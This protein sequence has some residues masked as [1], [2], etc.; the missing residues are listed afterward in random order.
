MAGAAGW[1]G[2]SASCAGS[3]SACGVDCV[4][5]YTERAGR[6]VG[7]LWLAL[8][9]AE[10]V[11]SNLARQ[12]AV[13]AEGCA[14]GTGAD[15]TWDV[16]PTHGI[17][18]DLA[19]DVVG[20]LWMMSDKPVQRLRHRC[21]DAVEGRIRTAG[22]SVHFLAVGELVKDGVSEGGGQIVGIDDAGGVCGDAPSEF[23][24]D[25]LNGSL[26]AVAQGPTLAPVGLAGLAGLDV[27]VRPPIPLARRRSAGAACRSGLE[28]AVAV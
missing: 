6:Q 10:E 17:S 23:I 11:Q 16:Q 4:G 25:L 3:W 13:Q 21:C 15:V 8:A 12:P 27:R 19:N 5:G 28:L 24:G 2:S 14:D 22:G 20:G 9:G 26:G 7:R 18:D 1:V